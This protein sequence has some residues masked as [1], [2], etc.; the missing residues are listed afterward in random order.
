MGFGA[1]WGF[2]GFAIGDRLGSVWVLEPDIRTWGE[3]DI[4]EDFFDFMDEFKDEMWLDLRFARTAESR[5]AD[6]ED[7]SFKRYKK[8]YMWT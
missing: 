6:F 3:D 8:V 5:D 7:F 2:A 1:G 4:C